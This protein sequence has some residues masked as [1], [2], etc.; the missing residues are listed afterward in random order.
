MKSHSPEV[1]AR[2]RAA[3]RA[4]DLT[5]EQLAEKAGVSRSAVCQWETGRQ[6]PVAI[7][8]LAEALAV[9]AD[10]LLGF[11]DRQDV[12]SVPEFPAAMARR[13]EVA[14]LEREAQELLSKIEQLKA[15]PSPA[16][17]A[18]GL[19]PNSQ[20]AQDALQGVGCDLA[21]RASSAPRGTAGPVRDP[22]PEEGIVFSCTQ[23]P[24]WY[25]RGMENHPLEVGTRIRAARRAL[26]LTQ[27]QLAEKVGVRRLA[28]FQWEAGQARP[29]AV[30]RLAEALLVTADFLLTGRTG[31]GDSELTGV[32]ASSARREQVAALER[33]AQELL[34]KVEQLKAPSPAPGAGTPAAEAW[35]VVRTREATR[36][37]ADLS[38]AEPPPASF[39]LPMLGLK[40]LGRGSADWRAGRIEGARLADVRFDAARHYVIEVTG[41]SMSPTI[42]EG[43]KCV[44]EHMDLYLPPLA[45]ED[46]AVDQRPW[47]GL[48]GEVVVCL[49]NDG[50]T[51]IIKRLEVTRKRRTGFRLTLK[52][53]NPHAK[54]IPIERDMSLRVRG[55]V[56]CIL[57]SPR[58][59]E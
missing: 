3:R 9:T 45:D 34:A 4:L 50:D 55:V 24:P 28:V 29:M 47:A 14:A 51:A 42:R 53:D 19:S 22:A 58:N 12:L 18:S 5:Q 52:S 21:V 2:I 23:P 7:A 10:F 31:R 57:R 44:V 48:D 20:A 40:E 32:V 46:A 56:R 39:S 13:R 30:A 17:V 27:A 8:R 37:D 41:Q 36:G 33:Q 35:Q 15:P 11:G 1:G 49:L 38:K 43:D 26:R 59:V 54:A 6:R 25:G 16:P